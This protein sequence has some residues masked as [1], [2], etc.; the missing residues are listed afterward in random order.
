VCPENADLSAWMSSSSHNPE[1]ETV[2]CRAPPYGQADTPVKWSKHLRADDE[3]STFLLLRYVL[4]VAA[5][6]LFLFGGRPA[7]SPLAIVV[8]SI[9]LL[10]N[11]IVGQLSE[12]RLMRPVALGVVICFDIAWIAFGL[13]HEGI[14][15]SGSFVLYFLILFLAA[16]GQSLF[17][18]LGTSLVLSAIDIF[19]FILP[20]GAGGPIWTSQSLVRIPFMFIAALFYGYLAEK[21]SKEKEI[22][23]ARI[24]A[25]REIEIAIASSLD[26]RAVLAVLLEK[27]DIFLPYAVVTVTLVNKKTG[28]LEPTACRNIDESEW[29]AVVARR[30]RLDKFS[31]GDRAPVIVL[32]TQTDPRSQQSEFLRKNSLVS[33][34]R[35]PLVAKDEVSGFL[36]FFTKEEHVFSAAEVK[37]LATLANQAAIAIDN[38]QLYEEMSRSNKIKDE[39]L[40]IMSHELRTPIN[41]VMGYAKLLKEGALGEINSQQTAAIDTITARSK[42]LLDMINSLLYATSLE[43][44][45]IKLQADE[46]SLEHFL[47]ELEAHCQPQPHNEIS[48]IWDFPGELPKIETDGLK[49]KLILQN[50]IGNAIKFTE[51]GAVTTSVRYYPDDKKVEF[52]VTD[53]GIGIPPEELPYI[54]ERFHQVDSSQTRSF[55]GVGLG[56]YIVKEFTA[57]LDGKITVASEPGK[58]S[59]FTLTIPSE[60]TNAR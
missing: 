18:L 21:V 51:K 14:F 46:V 38:S 37:F 12:H 57:V 58:G 39:F 27:I 9:A 28:D 48:L 33:Y 32:N 59:T 53:T 13:W 11:V 34:L 40:N 47:L 42:A 17:L 4:I 52:A 8:I 1:M 24:Q 20:S 30:I 19:L 54:F 6:Y 60:H 10:S 55:E 26:L 22:G 16:V 56:L 25:L 15:G 43:G 50:I 3:A 44:S 5:A 49:L 41:V 36:T 29:K 7:A 23:E 35:M 2:L 45:G 31:E